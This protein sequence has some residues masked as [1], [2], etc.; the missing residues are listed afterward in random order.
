MLWRVRCE[1]TETREYLVE[2]DDEAA[3]KVASRGTPYS[4]IAS[5]RKFISANLVGAVQQVST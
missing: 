3:A 2:A 4:V 1:V 5:I